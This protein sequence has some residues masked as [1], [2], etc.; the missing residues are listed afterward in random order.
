MWDIQPMPRGVLVADPIVRA[1]SGINGWLPCSVRGDWFG[2]ATWR[3]GSRTAM[4]LA[5]S[6]WLGWFVVF[7]WIRWMIDVGGSSLQ[8]VVVY[9]LYKRKEENVN[10]FLLW[11]TL[12]ESLVVFWLFQACAFVST[13]ILW[14]RFRY[15][16]WLVCPMKG[17]GYYF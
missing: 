12:M 5:R 8:L 17:S 14:V 13:G 7:V 4:Q 6:P 2:T 10:V 16:L 1:S 11:F 9:L 3:S 15:W